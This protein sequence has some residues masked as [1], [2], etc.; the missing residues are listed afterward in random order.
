MGDLKIFSGN[1]NPELAI[2]VANH[3]N[4]K[5]SPLT[6][7]NFSDGEIFVR[8]EESVRGC[9][10]FIIQP[11]CASVNENLMELLITVDALKRASAKTI[12]VVVPYYGYARQDRKAKG[13]EAIT[14]KLVA[15]MIGAAGADR[16]IAMDLHSGQ[17]QGFFNVKVDHL[18]ALP[19]ITNYLKAKDLADVVVVSPDTGGVARAS[20]L[21]KRLDAP[22]AI[23]DK[24]RPDHNEVEVFN[25]IGEVN[26]KIAILLDDM[27]DTG[28]TICK[29]AEKLKED[30][31][32][33]VIAVATHPVFS[34]NAIYKLASS[35]IDEIVVTNTIPLAQEAK[36]VQKI[37]QLSV[38]DL[39]GEAISRIFT[40]SSVSEMFD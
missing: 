2:Q 33:Q 10:V 24:R 29:A 23:I 6:I 9:D 39:F 14:A 12:N 30:G 1:A 31:A 7:K 11:T 32:V 38:A 18:N 15:D 36:L 34:G 17:L 40:E 8:V 37:T 5:L 21:A 20:Q 26:G 4:L 35:V 16:V 3:L 25:V 13:R 19:T 28:G 22:I 27:I